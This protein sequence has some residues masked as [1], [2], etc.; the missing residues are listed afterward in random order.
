MGSANFVEGK[1][2]RKGKQECKDDLLHT[3]IHSLKCVTSYLSQSHCS[4]TVSSFPAVA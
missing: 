2:L 4:D 3:F 1:A